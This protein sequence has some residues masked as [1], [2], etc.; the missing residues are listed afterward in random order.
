MSSRKIESQLGNEEWLCSLVFVKLMPPS[1]GDFPLL[2]ERESKGPT[3]RALLG[4]LGKIMLV[5]ERRVCAEA[6]EPTNKTAPSHTLTHVAAAAVT[7][8]DYSLF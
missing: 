2:G 4:V 7:A 6:A 3:S 5:V 8:D 1:S